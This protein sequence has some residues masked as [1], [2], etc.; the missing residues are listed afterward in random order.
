MRDIY[1]EANL[2]AGAVYHY[3]ESKE[4]II[5]ASFAFDYQRSHDLFESAIASSDPIKALEELIEFLFKGLKGA[6]ALGAGRVNVQGW[7]EALINP[8]I[9]KTVHEVTDY[10]S[11]ALSRIITRAQEVDQLAKSLDPLSLSRLLISLYYGLELQ[12]ALDPQLDVDKYI[13]TVKT[14]LRAVSPQ[15]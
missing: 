2:S 9:Q 5:Q 13:N 14:L 4:Q 11:N 12:L 15:S 7:G 3:F 10:Y 6:A 8:E 1:E